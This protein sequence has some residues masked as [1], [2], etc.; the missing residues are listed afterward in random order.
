MKIKK[1]HQHIEKRSKYTQGLRFTGAT[2]AGVI[3][4]ALLKA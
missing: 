3:N 1:R 4:M 2:Q